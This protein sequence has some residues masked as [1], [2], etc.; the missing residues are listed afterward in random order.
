MNQSLNKGRAW[1]LTTRRQRTGGETKTGDSSPGRSTCLGE[2]RAEAPGCCH[3]A[4]LSLPQV[5][6]GVSG[7]ASTQTVCPTPVPRLH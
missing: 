1:G 6:E 5:Q 7:R 2:G 4:A 3:P